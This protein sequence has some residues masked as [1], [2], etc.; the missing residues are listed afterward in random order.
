[1]KLALKTKKIILAYEFM[2]SA[3][4]D[5]KYGDK[6]YHVHPLAVAN[7]LVKL[8]SDTK[9]EEYIAALL[10]DVVEDTDFGLENI[11]KLFGRK[12][13]NMV[14]LLTKKSSLSY[15]ENI[16]KIID[17]GSV[18]AARIKLADNLMNASGDKSKMSLK[19]KHRLDKKYK[20]SIETLINYLEGK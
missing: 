5:Q 2:V 8:F 16:E 6:P 3:H 9:E 14:N 10:H 15:K 12:V 7:K 19:R 13:S 1:M 18:G 17:S 20:K 4:G 11:Q